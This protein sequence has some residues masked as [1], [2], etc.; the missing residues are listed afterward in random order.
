MPLSILQ[1]A[2]TFPSWGGTELHILTLSDQLKKRGHRVV[3]ACRPDCWVE[4]RAKE[5]ELET[6]RFNVM[7]YNDTQDLKR[8]RSYIRAEKMD[9]L[10]IHWSSDILVPGLAGLQEGVKARIMSRH[11]PFPFRNKTGGMLYSRILF[12]HM[13]SVSNSV[14]MAL[15]SS[16]AAAHKIDVIHHGTDVTSFVPQDG[17]HAQIRA[18]LGIPENSVAIGIVGRIAPE[19]GH[20]VFLQAASLVKSDMPVSYV[21]VGEGPD[22]EFI[23]RQATDLGLA[24]RVLFAGFRSDIA[25]VLAAL[26]IVTVP[27]LWQEPCSAVI[28]QAMAMSKPVIGTR[29]GGTPEVIVDGETGLIVPPDDAAALGQAMSHLVGDPAFRISAGIAGRK[30]VESHFSLGGMVDKIEALYYAQMGK[31]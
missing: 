21:I 14:K 2:T 10:H 31:K 20:R 28:Q 5:M 25:D 3:V 23:R 24:D 15:V 17:D 4:A 30:R 22:E 8:I 27:S 12:T 29:V 19:K 26:D 11:V 13:V 16:G 9:V 1:F 7:K 18:G 6:V